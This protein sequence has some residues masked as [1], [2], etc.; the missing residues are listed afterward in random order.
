M[1]YLPLQSGLWKTYATPNDSFW[2]CNGTGVEEFAKLNDTIY[3]HDDNSVYV[4]LFI[5]SELDWPEKGL[6]IRQETMFPRQQGTTLTVAADAPA[7]VA[8]QLR[9]PYWT[10]KGEVKVNGRLLP[11][12][13]SPGSYLR[14]AGPWKTGDKVELSLPMHLHTAPMP[15]DESVQAVM[16]GPLVLAGRFDQAARDQW[17]GNEGPK[18]APS[19]VPTISAD[20][21]DASNWV[22]PVNSEPLV[23]RS[24]GQTMPLALIP[25]A[26]IV[27]ERYAVYWNVSKKRS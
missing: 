7:D 17:Y 3:F 25:L 12:F 1:Y 4:N 5:A 15:D 22:E 20:P 8:I 11:A 6:R 16:Y 26:E 24:I 21:G 27:H 18:G 13:A 9:I 10:R 19:A 14:L 2:C 23:F